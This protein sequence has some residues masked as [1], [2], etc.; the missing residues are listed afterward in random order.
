MRRY[1][2][3]KQKALDCTPRRI[4]FGR[5]YGC[6]VRQTVVVVMIVVVVVLVM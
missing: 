6:V 4:G 1:W 5:C 2:K 3:F